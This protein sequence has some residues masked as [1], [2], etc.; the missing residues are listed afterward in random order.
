MD[1]VATQADFI[2]ADGHKWMMAP[3]GCALFYS[4]P[5]A[6]DRLQLQQYGWHMRETLY[7]FETTSDTLSNCE[8]PGCCSEIPDWTIAQSARRFEPGSPNILGVHGLEAS[9]SMIDEIGMAQI[10]KM[11][12]ERS[13][14]LID[15]VQGHPKLELI[16]PA[17]PARHA[18]IVT[19]S[20]RGNSLEV[21]HNRLTKKGIQCAVRAGG[22]RFSPHFYTPM[23]QLE[24]AIKLL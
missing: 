4:S 7:D 10:E 9:L 11:V 1:G 20:V 22:I 15:A 16:T 23:G 18:G 19:F 21:I 2:V 14:F 12:L 5:E 24:E 8:Q 6:R 17:D 3:E 13:R